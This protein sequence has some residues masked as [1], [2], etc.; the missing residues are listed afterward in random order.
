M[1]R[2]LI[3]YGMLAIPLL[4]MTIG[5][6]AVGGA[7]ETQARSPVSLA[8][9]CPLPCWRGIEPGKIGIVRANRI[10]MGE[11]YT[12]QP[13]AR[14]RRHIHYIPPDEHCVV[15]LEH[16]EA[17]VIETRLVACPGLR[18]GDI[19]AA[20]GAP[21]SIG[22]NFMFYRFGDGIVRIRL[23]P[24]NCHDTLSPHTEVAYISLHIAETPQ[25]RELNWQGFAPNWR[26][27]RVSPQVPPLAC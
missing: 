15:R 18:T 5:A 16:F 22:P 1:K 11:G 12:S 13:V 14:D 23:R 7:D 2:L 27:L 19:I 21:H 20:L 25:A 4:T 10:L 17:L 8:A 3:L 9:R 24:R 26:Y 6:I